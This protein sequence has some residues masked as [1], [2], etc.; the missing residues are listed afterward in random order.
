[1]TFPLK[2]PAERHAL[3][4]FGN[5]GGGG[6]AAIQ[7]PPPPPPPPAPPILAS[8]GTA[9]SAQAARQAAAAAAGLGADSTIKT[10][11]QGADTPDTAPVE[12][13]GSAKG[14][15]TVTGA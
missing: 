7:P 15:K 1:M 11:A 3:Y 4:G 14:S 10:S 6:G 12:L 8:A 9:V 2:H 5:N 13:T